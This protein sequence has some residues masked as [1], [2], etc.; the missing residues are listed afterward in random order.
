M[1]RITLLSAIVL[2]Y[3][4]SME[5]TEDFSTL[6]ASAKAQNS[7]EENF[8]VPEL[9]CEGEESTFVFEFPEK[10]GKTALKVQLYGDD[11]ST[12]EEIEEWY[13]I[14]DEQIEGSG[15]VDFYYTFEEAGDY[16]I[17]YQIGGGGFTELMVTVENCGC[18]ESFNYEGAGDTYTFIYT[19]AED[20]EDAHL[21]FTFAQS[22]SVE[23]FSENWT[24]H[25]QTMQSNVELEACVPLTWK[26]TLQKKCDGSTPN[27]NV[28]TDF[29]VNDVSKKGDLSNIVQSCP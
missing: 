21:T 16:S 6:N 23:G 14:F 29:K 25:G 12:T 17:R 27:N 7:E 22:V 1:K 11:P 3:G 10:P 13:N 15:P 24:W 2:M 26:L 5:T 18:E 19:P 4:C 28:W 20:M 9:I 8:I